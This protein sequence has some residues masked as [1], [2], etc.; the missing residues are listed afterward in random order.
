[1]ISSTV[2]CSTAG[3]L[4]SLLRSILICAIFA[5]HSALNFL[6]VSLSAFA[7]SAS[8]A[9]FVSTGSGT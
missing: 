5:S 3:R 2:S 4:N 8:C 1:M 7:F 9:D 6:T